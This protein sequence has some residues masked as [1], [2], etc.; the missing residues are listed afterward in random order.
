[1]DALELDQHRLV[2]IR[3]V[4]TG[5]IEE[6]GLGPGPALAGECA[7]ELAL[8]ARLTTAQTTEIGDDPVSRP[9]GCPVGLNEDPVGMPLAALPSFAAFEKHDATEPPLR[10]MIASKSE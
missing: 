2:I 4:V 5:R 8:A 6:R 9:A 1:V 7:A 3:F 10:P